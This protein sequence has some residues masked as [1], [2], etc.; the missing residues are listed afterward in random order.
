MTPGPLSRLESYLERFRA[1]GVENHIA[2]QSRAAKAGG[3]IASAAPADGSHICD[4]ARSLGDDV[5]AASAAATKAFPKWR[6]FPGAKRR[7]LLHAIADRITE[8]AEEIAF[9][10]S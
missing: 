4:V 5:D 9:C 3:R 6:D 2:G 8:R 10:E 1:G 7:A